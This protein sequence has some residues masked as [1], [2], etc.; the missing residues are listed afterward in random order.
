[1]SDP[2][3]TR[4]LLYG[5]TRSGKSF[6]IANKL[7]QRAIEFPGCKQVVFRKTLADVTATFWT[8]TLRPVVAPDVARGYATILKQPLTIEYTNGSIIR[9][10]GLHVSEIDRALGIEYATIFVNEASETSW[11]SVPPLLTRLNDRTKSARGFQVVPKIILDC[12]PPTTRHYLH[13]AFILK[14]RPDTREALPDADAWAALQLNPMDNRDNLAPDYLA[15]LESLSPRDKQ[16]FYF[17]EFGQTSG[18]VFDNFDPETHIIDD[19]EKLPPGKIYRSIDFGFVHP[20]VCL[21]LH[22]ADDETVTVFKEIVQSGVTIDRLAERIKKESAGLPITA[23][24]SDHDAGERALLAAAGIQTQRADKQ[25]LP[26]I[27][28]VHALLSR[29]GKFK[30]FRSCKKT[31]DGFYSYRWKENANRDEVVKEQD[32]EM[33]ALRYGVQTFIA[34]P[35]LVTV[36]EVGWL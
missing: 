29:P 1:L 6:V 36:G 12:N 16:R 3:K 10:G 34:R 25:V 32:D 31:I 13:T 11:Q 33:D 28:S 30:I 2:L 8:E 22:V 17:G 14:Q 19:I 9:F 35:P 23:T 15:Q 7:R 5:G 20:F 24:C 21:W 4:I 26:G 27:N 18:L